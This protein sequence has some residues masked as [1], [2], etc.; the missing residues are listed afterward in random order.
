VEPDGNPVNGSYQINPVPLIE[1]LLVDMH[2][3]TPITTISARFHKY[4]QHGR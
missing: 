1:E 2:Q 3:D 4:S